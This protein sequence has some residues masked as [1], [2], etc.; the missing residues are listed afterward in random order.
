[1]KNQ[2]FLDKIRGKTSIEAVWAN[3]EVSLMSDDDRE[4][5]I[6]AEINAVLRGDSETP[7][8]V[9]DGEK[10]KEGEIVVYLLDGCGGC[11]S[12]PTCNS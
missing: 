6:R 1:M 2:A 4:A 12:K 5:A 10:P 3:E 9:Y 8:R 7:L 11:D